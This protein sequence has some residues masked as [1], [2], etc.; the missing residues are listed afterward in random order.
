MGTLI[1]SN[2]CRVAA[3][4]AGIMPP[5]GCPLLILWLSVKLARYIAASSCPPCSRYS[6]G[7][8]LAL[9]TT[10]IQEN[11]DNCDVGH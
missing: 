2:C 4:I 5:L 7:S 11:L 8:G 9:K 1:I 10:G 3:S 6:K